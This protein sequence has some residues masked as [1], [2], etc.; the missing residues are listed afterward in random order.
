MNATT[1]PGLELYA[2]VLGV[3]LF[4]FLQQKLDLKIGVARFFSDSK[5]ALGYINETR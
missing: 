4:E 2:A 3:E 5:V 1:I